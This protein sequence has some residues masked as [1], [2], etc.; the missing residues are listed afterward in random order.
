MATA[1]S[2]GF[3]HVGKI[4]RNA[5][6]F[7]V[8]LLLAGQALCSAETQSKAGSDP[9]ETTVALL[10]FTADED[11]YYTAQAAIGLA[12]MIQP[13]LAD[14]PKVTWVDRQ[15][16]AQIKKELNLS[17]LGQLSAGGALSMGAMSCA[18]LAIMGNVSV[19]TNL[20]SRVLTIN[21][22]DLRRAD[23]LVTRSIQLTGSSHTPM[24]IQSNDLQAAIALSRDALHSARQRLLD[25]AGMPVVAPLFL[26]NRTPWESLD[27]VARQWTDALEKAGRKRLMRILRFPKAME[28]AAEAETAFSG[29]SR[30]DANRKDWF[31]VADIYAWGYF[32]SPER[33]SNSWENMTLNFK[34]MGCNANGD[35]TNLQESCR[36]ADLDTAL[37][38]MADT[39][40]SMKQTAQTNNPIAS[41]KN[42]SS[43]LCTAGMFELAHFFDPLNEEAWWNS[44]VL[45]DKAI[46]VNRGLSEPVRQLRVAAAML[47]AWND[48][49]SAFGLKQAE[50]HNSWG[51]AS[52]YMTSAGLL[53]I[54]E[55]RET[56]YLREMP[57][58]AYQT[59]L[60]QIECELVQHTADYMQVFDAHRPRGN[61]IFMFFEP[62]L[63]RIRDPQRRIRFIELLWDMAFEDQ[64]RTGEDIRSSRRTAGMMGT[65]KQTYID[66]NATSQYERLLGRV[67][68][69]ALSKNPKP[70]EQN[71]CL[72]IPRLKVDPSDQPVDFVPVTSSG[73]KLSLVSA[74]LVHDNRLWVGGSSGRWLGGGWS[75]RLHQHIYDP[76]M[77]SHCLIVL[78][79]KR[80]EAALHVESGESFPRINAL[81]AD[82][83]TVW[84]AGS[85]AGIRLYR[86][87]GTNFTATT[88]R[89]EGVAD[90]VY[91]IARDDR[92]DIYVGGKSGR[93]GLLARWSAGQKAWMPMQVPNL[94]GVVQSVDHL[95]AWNDL[96]ICQCD[97]MTAIANRPDYQWKTTSWGVAVI[98]ASAVTSEG[99]WLG[100]EAGLTLILPDKTTVRRWIPPA[101]MFT[102]GMDPE[103][104]LM[105]GTRSTLAEHFRP[106]TRLPGSVT[107]L[108]VDGEYLWLG[109][110]TVFNW[111]KRPAEEN[112]LMVLHRPTYRWLASKHIP[113]RIRTLAVDAN[114]VWL[115][116]DGAPSEPLG[117]ALLSVEKK[118]FLSRPPDQW[119]DDTITDEEIQVCIASL[120]IWDQAK[121]AFF[122]GD[123]P[124]AVRLLEPLQADPQDRDVASLFLGW[125]HDKDGLNQPDKARAYFDWV[126]NNSKD[127]RLVMFANDALGKLK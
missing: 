61:W 125:C 50:K 12:E 65:I 20:G 25:T 72:M 81:F 38:R 103:R 107:T 31:Q 115:G 15:Q 52:T 69:P 5:W 53:G 46:P 18:D 17:M 35:S 104:D 91:A 110:T 62:T 78:D 28:A 21:I 3:C 68:M 59:W 48:Y 101:G 84:M 86:S 82:G 109:V 63:N 99:L 85:K 55:K 47:A 29:Y 42:L 90:V 97:D 127:A 1:L 83:D 76:R 77:S 64:A 94:T 66:A 60:D 89:A 22:V 13:A 58:D 123:F 75:G 105:R 24:V 2:V 122:L 8:L 44:I 67:S 39:V 23:D 108:A 7:A 96:V 88:L 119:M 106:K 36:I 34:F 117:T 37:G 45:P 56:V 120:P 16:L 70:S 102:R 9:G 41:R 124:K 73:I 19:D 30:A 80:P 27:A 49:Y 51:G 4:A 74:L 10:D 11:S 57:E 113:G 79:P 95:C 33:G 116:L 93:G 87:S 92:N 6:W 112:F 71:D 111:Y 32:E 114:R 43:L 40:L 100:T 121:Y 118:P 126:I 98:L 14:E 54:L 26:H